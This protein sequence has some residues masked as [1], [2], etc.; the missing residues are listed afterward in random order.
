VSQSV[1]EG[2]AVLVTGTVRRDDGTPAD[3]V[4][5]ALQVAALGTTAWRTT[6]TTTVRPGGFV[7]TAFRA[8]ASADYRLHVASSATEVGSDSNLLTVAVRPSV[9]AA[10]TKPKVAHGRPVGLDVSVPGHSGQLVAVQRWYR[11]AWHA[12][13]TVRLG[14]NGKRVV[15]VRP[16]A[17]GRYRYRFVKAADATHLAAVSKALQVRVS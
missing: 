13:G 10:V 8:T 12:A 15:V 2:A 6:G 5:V 16:A 9:I 11:N 4:T 14:A 7:T 17:K 3:G 1:T